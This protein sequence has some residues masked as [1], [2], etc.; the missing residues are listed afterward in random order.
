[1]ANIAASASAMITVDAT[2]PQ[3]NVTITPRSEATAAAV[4]A[5]STERGT[6]V[7]GR[8]TNG[9]SVTNPLNG[10][11]FSGCAEVDV[12]LSVNVGA[13]ATFGGLFNPGILLP[14]F[15]ETVPLFEVR[16][17]SVTSRASAANMMGQTCSNALE[18]ILQPPGE[19]VIPKNL[20][21]YSKKDKVP[22]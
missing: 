9:P 3:Q 17:V 14:L 22:C 20:S 15:S 7:L 21:R 19:A 4:P 11:T 5:V 18:M 8:D 13:S 2:L 6:I 1:M 12:G 10:I 16:T